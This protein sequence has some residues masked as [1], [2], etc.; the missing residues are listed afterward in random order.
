[1]TA[2]HDIAIFIRVVD[3]GSFAA[4][5]K[6]TGL[7]PSAISKIV[8]R[9]EDRLGVKLLQRTTRRLALSQEGETYSM[10]GRDIL[11]AIEAAEAEVTA[12]RGQPRGHIRINTGTAFAKHRLAGILPEFLRR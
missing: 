8:S 11:A 9:L 7:T 5:A 10:R 3:L 2:A 12:G 6:E 4:V 1:M